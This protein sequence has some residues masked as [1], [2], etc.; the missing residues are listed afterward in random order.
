MIF[1]VLSCPPPSP[2][3]LASHWLPTI[4]CC[5]RTPVLPVTSPP[6]KTHAPPSFPLHTFYPSVSYFHPPF[7]SLTIVLASHHLHPF[8][9]PVP[10]LTPSPSPPRR[11]PLPWLDDASG[12]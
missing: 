2:T 8:P 1:A 3:L 10:V 12:R 6:S 5:P 4:W 9:F 11:A 7:H